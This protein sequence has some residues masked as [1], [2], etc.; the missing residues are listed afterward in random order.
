M[1]LA[2]RHALFREAVRAVLE[3]EAEIH[4]R[5]GQHGAR[6]RRGIGADAPHV[7][8]LD[9]DLPMSNSPQTTAAIKANAPD[10]H[11]L[12]LS[13]REDYRGLVEVLDAGASGYL[14][15]ESPL[16]D[17]IHAT[18]AIHRGDTLVPPTML[19]PLLTGL[20]RRKR[21]HDEAFERI[22]RLTVREREVLAL[23]AQGSDNDSIARTLVISP[24]TAR[25]H[26]QNIL[27]KLG[28]TRGSKPP[29]SSPAAACCRTSS[30]RRGCERL[31][32]RRGR[33]A[34]PLTRPLRRL[35]PA[36][37]SDRLGKALA[38]RDL[39]RPPESIAR[40]GCIRPTIL[41]VVHRTVRVDDR[42]AGARE[43]TDQLCELRH[44]H[45][46]GTAEIHGAGRI[47]AEESP[48]PS[49]RSST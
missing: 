25:T 32:V 48:I 7:A 12:V 2:D 28:C 45:L 42:R 40:E 49:M 23:L 5:G 33:G 34:S 4:D 8:I 19:G 21:D 18:R 46:F 6:G 47:G 11:V 27:G 14:T 10:C 24:Q 29:R 20:L 22:T 30:E 31:S 37:P 39:W 36:D 43:R 9:A 26:I 38:E 13:A 41:G 3:S 1:L 35:V 44:R 16:A 15:R 17:L